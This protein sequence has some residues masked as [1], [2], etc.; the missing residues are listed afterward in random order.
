M[1][2]APSHGTIFRVKSDGSG[3]AL[4]R[5]FAGGAAD[6]SSP[7]GSLII[8]GGVL[9]GMTQGG[10]GTAYDGVGTIFKIN[11]DGSGFALLHSFA[12]GVGDGAHPYDSL[13]VYGGVLYGMTSG[14]GTAYDGVG[15][16]FKINPD[17]SG[18]AL[19][20][21]FAG[22]SGDG[23]EPHG[24]LIAFG[25][26][27]F[28]MT[29]SGGA[30]NKGTIFK[31][32]PDGSGYALLRSFAGGAGDG[33]EPNGSLI[34]SGG[35]LYGMT[36]YGGT[37][38]R[39]TVFK[40]NPDGSGFTV[41][42]SL[43]GYAEYAP[44]GSLID[45][46]GVLYGT[47]YSGGA[48]DRGTVFKINPDGS[49]YAQLHSFAGGAADGN[50]PQDSLI[51][52][53]GVLYG[54]TYYGGASND[55]TIFKIN[56]DG[57]GY[58]LFHSFRG[59]S[60]DGF[61]PY[62][63][64]IVLGG[65]LYGMMSSD[66]LGNNGTIFRINSDGS[67]YALLHYFAGGSGDGMTPFGSL[68]VLG[69]TLYGMTYSGGASNNGT[70]FK[71][72]PDGSGHALLHSFAGGAGD[73]NGP[74]GSLI[75]SGGV[76]YGMT[77]GGGAGNN[78]TI[79]K[80]NPDGSGYALLHGF[81]GGAG[82]GKS[83]FG[84]LCV[85]GGALYGM[86]Q[87]GGAG[88]LGTVF[89]MNPDGSGFTLLHSFVGGAGDGKNPFGSLCVLGGTLYGMTSQGGASNG[90][91]SNL[92]T[93]FKINPD[94][95]GYALLRSFGF[96]WEGGDG[97]S[98]CGNL[99][100][101]GGA[102]YGMTLG[103]GAGGTI[104]KIN[105]EGNGY[106]VLHFFAGS[107]L[108]GAN[109]HGSL[110]EYGGA[111]YGMTLKGGLSDSGVIF[112][113]A[114]GAT[115]SGTITSGGSPLPDVVMNGLPANPTTNASGQYLATV[116]YGWSGT[117]TPT[118]S[119][120]TFLPP[121][122][123]YT[124]VLVNQVS[125]NYSSPVVPLAISGTVSVGGIPLP[126][127]MM[128]GLPGNPVTNVSGQYTGT[129]NYGWTG[130]VTPS[131]DGYTFSPTDR[132]YSNITTNQSGQ[133]YTGSVPL[134]AAKN[135][136]NGD[137]NEDI[138]WRN[139]ATGEN[140]LWYLGPSGTELA[141]SLTID[142][143]KMFADA[144]PARAQERGGNL[145][146]GKPAFVYGDPREGANPNDLAR[147]SEG[148]V[149]VPGNLPVLLSKTPFEGGATILGL[150]RI[151]GDS[152]PS[153][154]DFNWQLVGTG[155][156]NGDGRPDI[157]W[158]NSVTGENG[159]WYMNGGTQLGAEYMPSVTDL[160]WQIA[161]A[162][163]FSGDGRPDILW[164]NTATGENY[165]WY[166]NGV[167]RIGGVAPPSITDVK[168]QIVGTG[169]FSGDGKPD[170]LWHNAVTGENSIW[171]MDGGTRIGG[172][173]PPMVTELS[174]QI[175]GVGDFNGDGKIDILWRNSVSGENGVWYMNGG[176]RLGAEYLLTVADLNWII[177]NR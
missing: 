46:G 17:G 52:S 163:D 154:T 121:S 23:M 78:G 45:Y 24:S 159:V 137:G 42:Y 36:Y 167:E 70:I 93:V 2:G 91:A 76:L 153:M 16:I 69:G 108:D 128:N 100:D 133:N 129:V 72:N 143:R 138:L 50:G 112:S 62:G 107:P 27:L 118:K 103:G 79:F 114:I 104:F 176:T 66:Y 89:K 127:V 96:T 147:V 148:Q 28:G 175:V 73:G 166:M 141:G 71:I 25:G 60:I 165:I 98:P 80:I 126:N 97:A 157:I 123:S 59:G 131:K 18:F 134:P 101:S 15:T 21:T 95:G 29:N 136:F 26:V 111:L 169:D 149:G 174:W 6:G 33:R 152:V 9:Y 43:T 39:G 63:S 158:R 132:F 1:T 14:G 99:I 56:P 74:Q 94:G 106:S 48:S 22:G 135:D 82:D 125:Q 30:G 162:A 10:G 102:L 145:F 12:G 31:I 32:N 87:L 35:V 120:C 7:N 34:A 88:N 86:T 115:I 90:G 40:I 38:G 57:S 20:H 150:M 124:N 55:G 139:M 119:G 81:G 105:P 170:I 117:V 68:C 5:S 67:G 83:P 156:F 172:D 65:A 49:G 75:E 3:Y 41:L 168:W 37:Y 11:P 64:L 4:L 85:S 155:D 171:Y 130:T 58:A 146:P 51:E 8:Y 110:I 177:V 140:Y 144:A 173:T 92:G 164:R 160:N 19:L 13:I 116:P 44:H 47:T 54:M 113:L 109:P 161:G 61:N 122:R 84:S 53:G 151:G 142:S 77:L